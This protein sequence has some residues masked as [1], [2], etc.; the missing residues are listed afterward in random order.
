MGVIA[1]PSARHRVQVGVLLVAV[2]WRMFARIMLNLWLFL[3]T[4]CSF[5]RRCQAETC[6]CG[7]E[8]GSNPCEGGCGCNSCGCGCGSTGTCGDAPAIGKYQP[9]FQHYTMVI[10][11]QPVVGNKTIMDDDVVGILSNGVLLDSHKQ[12]RVTKAIN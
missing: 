12:V 8:C 2:S 9:L 10:P 1:L 3:M 7:S 6:G 5:H 11:S 4:S